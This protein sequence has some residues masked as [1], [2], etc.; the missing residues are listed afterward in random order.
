MTHRL[1]KAKNQKINLCLKGHYGGK[2]LKLMFTFSEICLFFII[3]THGAI[4]YTCGYT[5]VN[6][7]RAWQLAVSLQSSSFYQVLP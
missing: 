6:K 1:L 2:Y 5:D 3:K 7:V 4:S